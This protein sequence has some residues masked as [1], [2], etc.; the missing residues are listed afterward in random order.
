MSFSLRNATGEG[1]FF[2]GFAPTCGAGDDISHQLGDAA[3]SSLAEALRYVRTGNCSAAP[4]SESSQA[5]TQRRRAELRERG[6][7][8]L[9]G[10]Y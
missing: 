9:V 5:R 6:F 8:Q 10:A 3:E 2:D 4:T 1:D 7:R